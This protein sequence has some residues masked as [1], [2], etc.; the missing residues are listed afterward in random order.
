MVIGEI[1]FAGLNCIIYFNSGI[2]GR[3]KGKTMN[4]FSDYEE[5]GFRKS[6]ETLQPTAEIGSIEPLYPNSGILIF[7]KITQQK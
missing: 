1:A 3:A 4:L 6:V 2:D 5:R 7:S